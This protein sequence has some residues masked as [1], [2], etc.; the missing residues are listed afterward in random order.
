M[1]D[2]VGIGDDHGN[3]ARLKDF[4]PPPDSGSPTDVTSHRRATIPEA[5]FFFAVGAAEM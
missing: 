4:I 2:A 5:R 1:L 3:S